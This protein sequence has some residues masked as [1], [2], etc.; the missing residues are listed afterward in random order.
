[1]D[2]NQCILNF[3]VYEDVY[4]NTFLNEKRAF[5][6]PTFSVHYSRTS[7]IWTLVIWIA[8]NLDWLGPWGKFV[9]NATKLTC[10]EITSYQNKY[11]TVLWFLELQVRHG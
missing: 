10:L 9:E 3:P 4:S 2:L 1:V 11:S 7:L 6:A 8:N 5:S